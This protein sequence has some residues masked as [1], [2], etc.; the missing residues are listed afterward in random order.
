M[1]TSGVWW[2][3][4][5]SAWA[6]RWTTSDG[7]CIWGLPVTSFPT[8]RKLGGTT[9]KDVFP[10]WG[11]WSCPLVLTTWTRARLSPTT[12]VFAFCSIQSINLGAEGELSSHFRPTLAQSTLPRRGLSFIPTLGI[13]WAQ[14]RRDTFLPQTIETGC[15]F[16]RWRNWSVWQA[17]FHAKIHLGTSVQPPVILC[18]IQIR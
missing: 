13:T 8:G 9:R 3:K 6:S 7:W 12:R 15:I 17:S 16:W 18:L 2:P 4:W 14:L 11:R 1:A 10:R 5:R